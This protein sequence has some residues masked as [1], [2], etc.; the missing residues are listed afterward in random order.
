MSE[1]NVALVRAIFDAQQR[2]DVEAIYA[3][4]SQEIEWH[5]Y[6][7]EGWGTVHGIDELRRRWRQWA[8]VFGGA[9]FEM[10]DPLAIGDNVVVSLRVS[11][12]SRGADLTL[13]QRLAM[14]W[15][16]RDRQVVR[17]RVYRGRS[18]ALEALGLSE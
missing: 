4:Y 16:L 13:E 14:V 17:A 3:L 7:W 18:E 1:E 15:T 11:G 6:V 9:R 12:R 5:D 2:G 10:S 8:E